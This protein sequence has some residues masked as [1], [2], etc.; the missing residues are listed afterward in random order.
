MSEVLLVSQLGLSL[1]L[2]V[3]ASG[4]ILRF[5]DFAATLRL[6]RFPAGLVRVLTV[7][8]PTLELGLALVLVVADGVALQIAMAA[9][10]ALMTAFTAWMISVRVRR[11]SLSCSC[12]GARGAPVGPRTMARNAVLLAWAL[13]GAAV[14]AATSSP[15]PDASGWLVLATA[16]GALATMLLVG[17]RMAR[18]NL[19]L[20]MR[21]VYAL[22][23]PGS[24][25][26][27]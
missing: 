2:V 9:V 5:E 25:E 20:T 24:A 12:F 27:T 10:A 4:K 7:A 16:G 6:S 23:N 8:V 19:V 22:R 17:L 18:P 3:A 13:C 15:L 11:I 14:A 1:V 26:V 21:A